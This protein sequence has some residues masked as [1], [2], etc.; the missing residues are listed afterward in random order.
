MKGPTNK[1]VTGKGFSIFATTIMLTYKDAGKSKEDILETTKALLSNNH[2]L[3]MYF[4][5]A[6]SEEKYKNGNK[7]FHVWIQAN[8]RTKFTMAELDK[9]G[10]IHG[11]YQ[12]VKTTPKKALAYI[13]KDGQYVLSGG[14]GGFTE[15][16]EDAVKTYTGQNTV[17]GILKRLDEPDMGIRGINF[18][19]SASDI[20]TE[21][22]GGSMPTL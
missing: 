22:K 6:V 19:R 10:S 8:S 5:I 15:F 21:P 3:P 9:I 20:H 18:K 12:E 13:L 1:P 17:D 14:Q 11:H 4:G 16:A 7:H 2:G